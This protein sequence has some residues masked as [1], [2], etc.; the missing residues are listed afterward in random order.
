[1]SSNLIDTFDIS[2]LT[3]SI[4]NHVNIKR[5]R[6]TFML[7]IFARAACGIFLSNYLASVVGRGR[8]DNI[9][10]HFLNI[11]TNKFGNSLKI[12]LFLFWGFVDFQSCLYLLW[13]QAF[14][15]TDSVNTHDFFRLLGG[16]Y[17]HSWLLAEKF[18]VF[19]HFHIFLYFLLRVPEP[20][21][22]LVHLQAEIS[23]QLKDHL[24][25]RRLAI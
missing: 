18:H 8:L 10:R 19:G 1:M 5:W 22:N 3:W 12:V 16:V 4:F 23:C 7:I 11:K 6:H 25:W 15:T 24:S 20:L 13:S 2:L 17:A 14:S 9:N 21:V